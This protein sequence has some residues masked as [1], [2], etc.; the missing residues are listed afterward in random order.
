VNPSEWAVTEA[1]H[2]YL[3]G[4]CKCD[5]DGACPLHIDIA[6][7][8]DAAKAAGFREG[9]S[10][11]VRETSRIEGEY[12]TLTEKCRAEKDRD[13]VGDGNLCVMSIREVRDAIDK[14]TPEKS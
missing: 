3:H 14:L 13:G 11:C 12:S 1:R 9:V 7:V 4:E 5:A 8:L 6:T 10:A 2:L